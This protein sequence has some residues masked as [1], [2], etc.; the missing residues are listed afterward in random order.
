MIR[1]APTWMVMLPLLFSC[2]KQAARTDQVALDEAAKPMRAASTSQSRQSS[3]A[4]QRAK[5][6]RGAGVAEEN[7]LSELW[8]LADEDPIVAWERAQ[9]LGESWEKR[10]VLLEQCALT[11]AAQD[12][13][14]A[15]TWVSS[16]PVTD[17][18]QAAA[19]RVAL[20][21]AAKDP[22]HAMRFIEQQGS[23]GHSLEVAAVQ[24]LQLWAQS[25]GAEAAARALAIP[26]SPL[27][28]AG[29]RGVTE[30]WLQLDAAAYGNWLSTLTSAESQQQ[31]VDA[32]AKVL[33]ERTSDQRQQ[34]LKTFSPELQ[35]QISTRLPKAEP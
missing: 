2:E 14:R 35:Q 7:N 3:E 17:E 12:L 25:S 34:V 9:D 28:E 16:L 13:E 22:E 27:R 33:G 23:G 30:Q 26:A 10:K 4:S 11:L 31:M 8:Q 19:A 24:V 29:L 32:T 5:P 6:E 21:L 18:R 1:L 20:V 15:E